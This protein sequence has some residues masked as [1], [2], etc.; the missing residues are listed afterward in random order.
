MADPPEFSERQVRAAYE[1]LNR[2]DFEAF[3]DLMH[4]EVEFSSLVAEMEGETYRG[5]AGLR[6]WWDNVRAAFEEV[7]WDL[8]DI[9]LAGEVAVIR[10]VMRGQLAGVPVEQRMWQLVRVRDEQPIGWQFFRSEGEAVRAA[11]LEDQPR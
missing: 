8:E 10:F 1:A 11:G 7:V 2:G 5:R 6:R 4:P 9:R 3:A